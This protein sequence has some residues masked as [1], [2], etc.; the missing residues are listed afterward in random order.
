VS[1]NPSIERTLGPL[2]VS[3]RAMRL[4]R[5]VSHA[6]P[7]S[8]RFCSNVSGRRTGRRS[9]AASSLRSL[10]GILSQVTW[11]LARAAFARF[12]GVEQAQGSLAAVRVIYSRAPLK[13][14]L[15]C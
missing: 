15:F 5:I 10:P 6:S 14:K 9:N 13:A 12:V 4:R 3:L 1:P 7:S 8:R 2:S 11:C